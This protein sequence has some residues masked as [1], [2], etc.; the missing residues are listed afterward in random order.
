M[1]KI[2][3]SK[4]ANRYL[5]QLDEVEIK[6]PEALMSDGSLPKV[7]IDEENLKGSF[8]TELEGDRLY[9]KRELFLTIP[10]DWSKTQK[11]EFL[12]KLNGSFD[13]SIFLSKTAPSINPN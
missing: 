11:T 10:D 9:L 4:L 2:T 1:E 3:L 5:H 12:K 6:L 13:K 8:I 7:E